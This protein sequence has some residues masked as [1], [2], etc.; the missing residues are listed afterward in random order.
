LAVGSGFIM[1]WLRRRGKI[2]LNRAVAA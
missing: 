1:R 2:V